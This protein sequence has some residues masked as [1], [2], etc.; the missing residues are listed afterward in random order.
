MYYYQFNSFQSILKK[1][2]SYLLLSK[3]EARKDSSIT[4]L[5]Y[6]FLTNTKKLHIHLSFWQWNLKKVFI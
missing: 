1:I 3:Q 6:S 4:F 2:K 5:I